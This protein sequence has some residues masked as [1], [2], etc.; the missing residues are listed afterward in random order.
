MAVAFVMRWPW[1]LFPIGYDEFVWEYIAQQT[2]KGGFFPYRDVFDNKPPLVYVPFL[3]SE[4]VVGHA[5][6][7][8]RAT[9]VFLHV[10]IVGLLVWVLCRVLGP[11]AATTAGAA[12]AILGGTPR[13]EGD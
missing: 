2:L 9:G 6:R 1:R 11:I 10:L 12:E 8:V 3:F 4:I 5:D 13:L 7:A